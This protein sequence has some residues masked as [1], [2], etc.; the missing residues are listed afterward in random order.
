MSVRLVIAEKPSVARAV[1]SVLGA[2]EK[3][4]GYTQGNGYIVSWCF[5]HLASLYMPNDYGEK[6]A[7]TWSFEQLPIV[8]DEWKFKVSDSCKQQYEILRKLLNSNEVLD[9]ICAT[10][11][12]REGECI[13]RYVY[14][15]S[16][17]TKPV[18][19]LWISSLEEEAVLDGF[20][21]L[22]P[23][24]EYDNLFLAGFSRAKADWLV[25]M[26]A[27]RL[28]SVRY[29]ARL[30]VGRV[31]TPT[32][33]MIVRRDKD[34]KNFV[35]QKFFT[36]ELDCG[37]FSAVSR[38]I[39]SKPQATAL[40]DK[41]GGNNAV[42]TQL[43]KE[44][45]TINPPK[46]FDLTSLQRE[47]NVL[48]GYT[49]QQTLDYQ[50]SLY[51]AKLSTYPR[52]DSQFITEDMAE[53]TLKLTTILKGEL[54]KYDFVEKS[55]SFDIAQCVSNKNVVSHPAILPTENVTAQAI[56]D[57]PTGQ[58]NILLLEIARLF[59]AVSQPHKYEAVNVTLECADTSFTSSGRTVTQ[60]GFKRIEKLFKD[61]YKNKDNVAEKSLPDISEGQR[62]AKV[63]ASVSE[64]FTSP[65]KPYTEASLLS[66]MEHAGQDD[67]DE[68]TEKKGIGTPATRA[69]VIEELVAK[70]FI[71]RK[72]KQIISTD[73]GSNL[74]SVVPDEVKS[75]KLTA[76]W[77]SMLKLVEMGSTSA[78]EFMQG[79]SQF[80]TGLCAKYGSSDGSV[81]F[82][83]GKSIG[84]CPK[85]AGD[86]KKGKYG[87]YCKNKCGM[88]VAK[89]YG[90]ELSQAQ[91]SKLLAGSS[92]TYTSNGRKTTVL[93]KY[94]KNEYN[95]KVYYQWET[96]R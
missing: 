46:L 14:N 53:S 56:K 3:H 1:Y 64:H 62:F 93:P 58:A 5:G 57:L 55:E 25:G 77:E 40:A 70:G 51:E 17:S 66:A 85:C 76:D 6:W 80:V 48:F 49:A 67:F 39:D 41:C 79:I 89:V 45:K 54:C 10:D 91:L 26:N 50:Q 43:A 33:S 12:D 8:P 82:S 78:D 28:F 23:D 7:G 61:M 36:V 32:L 13:F 22:K 95:G 92:V 87:F 75:P 83:G 52:T 68:E 44:I 15:L 47:A 73:T 27:S 38:R 96:K 34:I 59:C 86:V 42:V 11:A 94:T 16:G 18:Y 90:K 37:E 69:K 19:R 72:G 9:V 65:P 4:E 31:Q 20:A 84:K 24:S 35:K 81:S 29:S 21:N 71:E 60:D 88:N 30:S 63:S 2:R 74:I